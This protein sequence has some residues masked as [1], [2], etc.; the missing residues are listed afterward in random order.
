MD[1]FPDQ[2]PCKENPKNKI[3][4]SQGIEDRASHNKQVRTS[5]GITVHPENDE[6]AH[7]NQ[8]TYLQHPGESS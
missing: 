3:Q 4:P 1:Q 8:A 7:Q 6:I 5:Q 2:K